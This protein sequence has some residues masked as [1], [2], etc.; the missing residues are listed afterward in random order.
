MWL[1]VRIAVQCTCKITIKY[2]PCG[3]VRSMMGQVWGIPRLHTQGSPAF[4]ASDTGLMSSVLDIPAIVAATS[5]PLIG[6]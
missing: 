6:K 5:V 1:R 4:P 2:I 3:S